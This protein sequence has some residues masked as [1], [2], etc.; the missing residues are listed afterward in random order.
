MHPKTDASP[1]PENIKLHKKLCV[2][3]LVYNP[4]ETK[5]L[6]EAKA[7]GAKAVSGLG[8]LIR[9]GALAFTVFT[10]KPAPYYIMREAALEALAAKS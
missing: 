2:Y 6:R 10:G 3:D 9:Q 1:L 7:A 4:H 5:L 8:M